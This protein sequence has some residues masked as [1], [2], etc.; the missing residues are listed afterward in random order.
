MTLKTRLITGALL[1]LTV[2][3]TGV[4]IEA[5]AE[6]RGFDDL[7]HGKYESVQLAQFKKHKKKEFKKD[8]HKKSYK[9]SR[10]KRR[11]KRVFGKKKLFGRGHF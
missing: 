10:R 2:F 6:A 3:T 9:Y 1:G 7:H 11:F 8:H 5:K 4:S